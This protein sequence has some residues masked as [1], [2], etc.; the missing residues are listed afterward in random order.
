MI[1]WFAKRLGSRLNSKVIKLEEELLEREDAIKFTSAS[2]E[3]MLFNSKDSSTMRP[4]VRFR[5]LPKMFRIMNPMISNMNQSLKSLDEN[6]T[7]P[8]RRVDGEFIAQL[9]VYAYEIGIDDIAYT[10]L[11][12]D[13]IFKD[14]AVVFDGGVIVLSMEMDYDKMEKAP[15][16]DTQK[17]IL[18]TY[19]N[20]GILTNKITTYLRERGY[21]AQ[22]GH[23]LGGLTVYPPLG[24]KSGMG[25]HG[26]N[27]ILIGNIN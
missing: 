6:P 8:K 1:G 21:G 17:M 24:Q 3:R 9:E 13:L 11:S 4:P 26:L 14:R 22:A 15:S 27:G 5:L 23:P 2:P 20:L 7:D 19:N 25:W 10:T 16:P 18:G 12:R